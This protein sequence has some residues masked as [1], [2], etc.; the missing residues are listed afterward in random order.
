MEV[1]SLEEVYIK[2][3]LYEDCDALRPPIERLRASVRTL[4]NERDDF[5]A[6]LLEQQNKVRSRA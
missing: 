1:Y 2:M 4:S 3:R 5:W 6:Q